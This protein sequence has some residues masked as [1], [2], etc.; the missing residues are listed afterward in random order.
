M[1]H[2]ISPKQLKTKLSQ[3]N[4]GKNFKRSDVVHI[5]REKALRHAA[6]ISREHAYT[7]RQRPVN[8]VRIERH[9]QRAG[10][11]EIEQQCLLDSSQHIVAHI[12]CQ[13]SPPGSS[14]T[15]PEYYRISEKLLYDVDILI[16][17]SFEGRL[18]SS[19]GED[20]LIRSST[21]QD[22][23]IK[24]LHDFLGHC[25]IGC[26]AA[27]AYNLE[28]AGVYWGRAFEKVEDLVK[29]EYY[30]IIP[31]LIQMINDLKRQGLWELATLLKQHVA[32]CSKKFLAPNAS[33]LSIFD[34]LGSLDLDN[35]VEIEERIMDQFT[36]LFHQYLGYQCYNSFVMMMDASRR[37]LL[38]SPWASFDCLPN[39]SYLDSVFGPASRW[40]LDLIGIRAEISMHRQLHIEAEIEAY[41][42]IQRA[43]LIQKDNWHRFYNLTRGHYFLG[44][45]QYFLR[46]HDQAV[47]SLSKALLFDDELCKID[48]FHIFDAERLIIGKYLDHLLSPEWVV[49]ETRNYSV[50]PLMFFRCCKEPMQ[51]TQLKQVNILSQKPAED[52]LN[53]S[54]DGEEDIA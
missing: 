30:D 22:L 36:N 34:G 21:S 45:A 35:M 8:L 9:R 11:V 53:T 39:V 48:E 4:Y 20:Q 43:E 49:E 16:K 1:M 14:P 52:Y 33:T 26:H 2:P 47:H 32:Q 18:W 54:H 15:L 51:P 25:A 38:R 13:N 40:T 10:L 19:K 50:G 41:T 28:R 7:L 6:G 42:L 31:N 27:H 5:L 37:K 3:W 46:K 44:S 23:E 12:L 29:G 24:A 17:G